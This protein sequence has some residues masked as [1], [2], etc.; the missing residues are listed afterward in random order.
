MKKIAIAGSHG[1]GKTTLAFALADSFEHQKVVVNSQIARTLI[2]NGYPLGKE[3]A[4]GSYIRY[5]IEQLQ[6]E[7]TVEGCSVF[8]SDRTLL[9]PLAYAIVNKKYIG[10][11]VPDSM[12]ELLKAVWLLEAQQYDLYVFVPIEFDMQPDGIRPEGEDYRHK[13][14][15]QI[16]SLLD[17]YKVGY[18]KVSGTV[19]ERVAQVYEAAC[20]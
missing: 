6:A 16:R 20:I 13:L 8:I 19:K 18:I 7:R 4:T 3:A 11:S 12:I 17:E 15:E 9:D 14:D 10:S 1:V 2:K 5:I